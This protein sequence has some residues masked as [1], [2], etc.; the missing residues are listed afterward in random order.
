MMGF[1]RK[2]RTL[3]IAERANNYR[4][5]LIQTKSVALLAFAF[6]N[7]LILMEFFTPKINYRQLKPIDQRLVL[8]ITSDITSQ[9]I[10]DLT[11]QERQTKSLGALTENE[12]LS[13]AAR[14]KALDMYKNQYW[15]HISP[16]GRQPWDFITDQG[17]VYTLAG[18]NLARDFEHADQVLTA[19]MNSPTHKENILHDK[20]QQI[21]VAVVEGN[22][23]GIETTL[24][25]Q[26]FA[27]PYVTKLE[28]DS[29]TTNKPIVL[30]DAAVSTDAKVFVSP[31]SA[32]QFVISFILMTIISVYISNFVQAKNNNLLKVSGRN[33][34]HALLLAFTLGMVIFT[35]TGNIL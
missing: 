22:L 11:N 14:A 15:S 3:F 6:I 34:A 23:E 27:S 25:V 30:G 9:Q 1:L 20:Y 13:A 7:T 35:S 32:A 12:Q 18:E 28:Q 29:V 17:Y 26:M 8:G 5:L 4:P 16:A 33:L 21:G 10:I 2:I 31:F 24:V 19:W